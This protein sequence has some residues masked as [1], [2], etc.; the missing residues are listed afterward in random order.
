MKIIYM[1]GTLNAMINTKDGAKFA[2]ELVAKGE[3]KDLDGL[4]YLVI[5]E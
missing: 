2:N 4:R 5:K 3:I 1:E